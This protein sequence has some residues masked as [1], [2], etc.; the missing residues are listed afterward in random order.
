MKSNHE[1]GMLYNSLAL[2]M[3]CINI[4]ITFTVIYLLLDFFQLGV[5]IDHHEA[6]SPLPYWIDHFTRTL[7]F[8]AITLLS[9]GYGDITPFG[10]SRGAAIV[11]A[12]I[13]YILPA[14]ITV[15]YMRLF[16]STLR[17]KE[18]KP[19]KKRR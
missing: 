5:I 12:S 9:V 1:R 3:T 4:I 18:D 17:N 15:Q 19:P 14:V 8:S 6:I 10:W 7:Y 11:E 16:P 2:F 13:G